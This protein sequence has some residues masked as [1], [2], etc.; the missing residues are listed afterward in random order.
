MRAKKSSKKLQLNKITV[1]CLSTGTLSRIHGGDGDI[2]ALRTRYTACNEV[3]ENYI[4]S[5]LT[6]CNECELL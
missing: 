1:D 4:F 6:Y 3:E 5:G 2:R